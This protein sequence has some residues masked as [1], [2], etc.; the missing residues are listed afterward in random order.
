MERAEIA[1]QIEQEHEAYHVVLATY[2]Q[3]NSETDIEAMQSFHLNAAIF[4]EGHKMKN[5]ETKLYR[6]L[7][8]IPAAWKMLLTGKLF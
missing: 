5:P 6:D 4:D 3:I 8:R 2:S 7:R 1:Y